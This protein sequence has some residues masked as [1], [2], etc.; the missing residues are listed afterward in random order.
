MEEREVP[1]THTNYRE[2]CS[3][4]ITLGCW[5]GYSEMSSLVLGS[6]ELRVNMILVPYKVF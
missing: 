2:C 3:H 5:V 6:N 1:G 4:V